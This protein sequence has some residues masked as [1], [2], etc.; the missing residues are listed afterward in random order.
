LGEAEISDIEFDSVSI[1]LDLNYPIQGGS[2]AIGNENNGTYS[3]EV[4]F[5]GITGTEAISLTD[6]TGSTVCAGLF[7]GQTSQVFPVCV[8]DDTLLPPSN[9]TIILKPGPC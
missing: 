4:F 6:S 5:T 7:A 3:V 2:S 1:T 8:L 9:F